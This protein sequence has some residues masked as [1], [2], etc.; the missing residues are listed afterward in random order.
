MTHPNSRNAII[1]FILGILEAIVIYS[2]FLLMLGLLSSFIAILG[3]IAIW[4]FLGIGVI[5][6]IYVIPRVIWLVQQ[7]KWNRMK[8]V[9]TAAV[10]VFLLNGGGWLYLLQFSRW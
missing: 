6:L 5:Q 9:V 4:A 3:S 2:A 8:G 10:I 7:R 1:D